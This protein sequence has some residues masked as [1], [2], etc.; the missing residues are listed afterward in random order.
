MP[1]PRKVLLSVLAITH[2]LSLV[3]PLSTPPSSRTTELLCGRTATSNHSRR[4]SGSS[5]V[6]RCRHR[7]RQYTV[8]GEG[9]AVAAGDSLSMAVGERRAALGRSNIS[10]R[11]RLRSARRCHD[12]TAA[13]TGGSGT[14]TAAAAAAVAQ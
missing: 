12:A 5:R 13:P 3:P 6:V 2:V 11:Q 9:G 4:G 8:V 14:G 10:S 1:V 7:P